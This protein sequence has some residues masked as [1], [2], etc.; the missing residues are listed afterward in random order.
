MTTEIAVAEFESGRLNCAQSVLRAFQGSH[1]VSDDE[2][3]K[4]RKLGGGRAEGGLC[5]ALYSAL[6]LMGEPALS[7]SLRRE[8]VNMAGSD[9]CREIAIPCVECVRL[10]ASL[11]AAHGD[12]QRE[13]LS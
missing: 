9:K 3:G 12:K 6:Q 1:N 11:L 7:E 2:I 13:A 4:A 8:F 10:A 5:G